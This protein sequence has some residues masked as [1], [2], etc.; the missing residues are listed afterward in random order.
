MRIRRESILTSPRLASPRLA[1]GVGVG[2]SE[3]RLDS[4]IRHAGSGTPR[5]FGAN[6]RGLD[7]RSARAAT[8]DRDRPPRATVPRGCRESDG[9]ELF[10]RPRTSHSARL[11]AEHQGPKSPGS[12]RES[13]IDGSRVTRLLPARTRNPR[14]AS[15]R[16]SQAL[17]PTQKEHPADAVAPSHILLLRAG[18]IRQLGAGAYSYL[19]L[20]LRVLHKADED[21]PRGDGRGRCAGAAHAGV[22]A[23]GDL[24]GVGASRPHGG[25]SHGVHPRRRTAMWCWGRRTRRRSRTSSATSSSRTSRC[26]ITLYQVQTKFRNEPRPRFGILRTR[27]FIMKDAYSF[28]AEPRPARRRLRRHVRG[29]LP[30]LRPLRLP[31]CRRRGR[32]RADR[33]RQLAR[34]HGPVRDGRG[35]GHPLREVRTTPPIA[36]R[37]RSARSR[38]PPRPTPPRPAYEIRGH[39]QS[40]RTIAEVCD[41]LKVRRR[42]RRPSSWCSWPTKSPVA[43]LIRGDHEANE[44]KVRRAL[45]RLDVGG[46]RRRR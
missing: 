6:R 10:G 39:A 30:H 11:V 8:V 43:V 3:C 15:V 7:R 40:S 46:G 24:E 44:G 31:L 12:S 26:P 33:R 25:H 28:A 16:W 5:P 36:R 18:M 4:R 32:E 45:P 13:P 34:V 22:A 37:P 42:P 14:T 1:G 19:P 20:G 9:R 2:A 23:G 27:E 21:R 38:I 41:F 35:R 17:I 29:V